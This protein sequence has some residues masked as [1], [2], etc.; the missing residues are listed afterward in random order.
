MNS[1]DLLSEALNNQLAASELARLL[2]LAVSKPDIAIQRTS[3]RSVVLLPNLLAL[4]NKHTTASASECSVFLFALMRLRRYL[5]ATD[6]PVTTTRS[7]CQ[8]LID[9]LVENRAGLSAHELARTFIAFSEGQDLFRTDPQPLQILSEHMLNDNVLAELN[10]RDIFSYLFACQKMQFRPP[11][12][13]LSAICVAAR[14]LAPIFTITEFPSFF[15]LANAFRFSIPKETLDVLLEEAFLFVSSYG[16]TELVSLFRAWYFLRVRIKPAHLFG[17]LQSAH[18]LADA[19]HFSASDVLTILLYS[20]ETRGCNLPRTLLQ[21]LVDAA[22]P[23]FQTLAER[24]QSR[25]HHVT[26]RLDPQL[27][28][29]LKMQLTSRIVSSEVES[30]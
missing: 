13:T 6:V 19:G 25:L 22:L 8:P 16:K 9:R 4:I 18:R 23:T 29:Y 2:K 11:E 20:N 21:P 7:D 24:H 28:E 5:Q 27:G 12:A 15:F 3:L 10:P 14:R 1:S 17:Y 30:N 26:K